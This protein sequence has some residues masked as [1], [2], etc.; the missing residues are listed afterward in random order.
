MEERILAEAEL[1]PAS[2]HHPAVIFRLIKEQ[3]GDYVTEYREGER[4]RRNM[5]SGFSM[6]LRDFTDAVVDAEVERRE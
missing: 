4:V 5:R 2:E 3:M 1:Q 6:A